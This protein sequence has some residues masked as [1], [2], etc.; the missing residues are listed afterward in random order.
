MNANASAPV[1]PESTAALTKRGLRLAVLDATDEAGLKRWLLADARGFHEITPTEGTLEVQVEDIATDRVT[2]VWDASQAD[3][4]TPVATVR[5]WEMGLTV[6][7]GTTL[8]TWAIS[9]VTVSPTHRRQGI[10]RAML[11]SELRTAVRLGLPIAMLTVSEATIYGRYGFGPSARQSSYLVDTQ[12]A[13]WTGPTPAGRVQ[14]V[15]PESLLADG[16]AVFE[17]TRDR[18]PGEV[19]R[20]EIWW[21]RALGLLPNEPDAHKRGIRAVRYDDADGTIAGFALYEIALQN[22]SQPGQLKLVDLVAATD[23]AYAAL[24]RFVIEMD[25]VNEINAGLRSVSEPVAW[26]VSDHRAVRKTSERDHLWLRILDVPV[27][28]GARSYAAPGDYLLD[29]TDDLGFA[30]GRFLLTVAADGSGKA[31]P[32]T[33]AAP[34]GAVEVALSAADLASLYLGGTSAVDLTRAGRIAEKSPDAALRLDTALRSA[35]APHLS[36]WF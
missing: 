7:G 10:A 15:S 31:H 11:T 34:A 22:V 8:G 36:T 5:S 33:G 17:R 28:L 32:L 6:P 26:Q 27:A 16:P 24:W 2:G 23:D 14:F 20:R 25:M 19:D 3:P 9:S 30:Q 29:V 4:E 18:S 13:H 35:Y 12:R 21:K 1:D